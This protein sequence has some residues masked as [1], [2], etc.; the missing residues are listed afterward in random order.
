MA[1]LTSLILQEDE[2][3][4]KTRLSFQEIKSEDLQRILKEQEDLANEFKKVASDAKNQVE[5]LDTTLGAEDL[6]K[7]NEL[8]RARL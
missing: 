5:A 4:K 1:L 6:V 8:S 2:V 3:L 7:T